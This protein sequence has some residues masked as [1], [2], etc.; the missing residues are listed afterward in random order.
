[1]LDALTQLVQDGVAV[2]PDDGSAELVEMAGKAASADLYERLVM[3]CRGEISIVLTGTNQTVEATANKAS[4]HAGQEVADDLRDGDAEIVCE[5]INELIR[6]TCEVN[7]PGA[8]PPVFEMW[9]QE[10]RDVTQ[11]ARDKSNYDAGARF[12]NAY[13]VREYGYQEGDLKPEGT[14]SADPAALQPGA[15]PADVA[16][17]AFAEAAGVGNDAADPTAADTRRL[18][19]A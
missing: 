7:W 6:W 12:T 2:L 16:A 19:A 9:D 18:E 4:A 10:S 8:E 14:P 17:A 15:A 3:Y 11:A 1:M 13:W 5:A